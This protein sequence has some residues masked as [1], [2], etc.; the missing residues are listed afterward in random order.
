MSSHEKYKSDHVWSGQDMSMP[1]QVKS[2]QVWIRQVR[3]GSDQVR[4][5]IGQVR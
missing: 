5:M 2:Y 4:S 1:G 3:I